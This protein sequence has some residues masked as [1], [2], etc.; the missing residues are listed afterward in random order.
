MQNKPNDHY[1]QNAN[2]QFI[3]ENGNITSYKKWRPTAPPSSYSGDG[4][5]VKNRLNDMFTRLNRGVDIINEN[6]EVFPFISA[7]AGAMDPVVNAAKN[8]SGLDWITFLSKKFMENET[9]S[10]RDVLMSHPMLTNAKFTEFGIEGYPPIYGYKYSESRKIN[11]L[12]NNQYYSTAS[13]YTRWPS[14][15]RNWTSAWHGWQWVVESRVNE[16]AVNDRLFSPFVAAG[17]DANEEVNVRPAQWL[18]LM[19]CLGMSGAEFYYASFFSLGAP[20]PDSKNWIWQASIPS[21][22]QAITSRYE[23][24][25]R[26]GSLLDGDVANSYINPTAP[27]Y[28]FWAGDL[29]KLVIVRKH[30]TIN[31][32]AITGTLQPNTNIAGSTE[33]E[34]V[35]KIVLEGQ[36]ISFK[37]RRQGN[38]YIYDKSNPAAPVFYQLDGWHENTHPSRWSKDFNLESE[39]LITQTLR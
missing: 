17:W 26:N 22:A 37:V 34:S 13:V 29:R 14:N 8:A 7:T 27:G 23:D 36:N 6:G 28:S 39:L 31:K 1:L 15:W 9:Q 3:D 33:T 18:G 32:F 5:N 12:I 35:A 2:G 4:Y 30:N 19:K 16:L 20:W 21:Y 11:S 10:Y 38:T 25:L 24:F